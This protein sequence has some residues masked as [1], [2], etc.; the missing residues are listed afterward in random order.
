[1]NS[2][3]ASVEQQI[4]WRCGWPV[5]VVPV[6]TDHTCCIAASYERG[7]MAFVRAPDNVGQARRLCPQFAGWWRRGTN[8]TS[9][10]TSGSSQRWRPF[11][12]SSGFARSNETACH[13]SPQHRSL[14]EAVILAGSVK[15]PIAQHVGLFLRCSIGLATNQFLAKVASN[16]QKPDGLSYITREDLPHKLYSLS[17]SDLPGIGRQMLARLERRGVRLVEQLCSLS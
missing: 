14:Q 7:L 11:Y 4:S 12:L 3:F 9:A 6:M 15:P 8:C 10:P 2:Y 17:L 16:M 5:A 1:M 13:L